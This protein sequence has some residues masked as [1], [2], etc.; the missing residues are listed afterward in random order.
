MLNFPLIYIYPV[1]TEIGLARTSFCSK[2]GRSVTFGTL[3]CPSTFHGHRSVEE[4][5]NQDWIGP[6]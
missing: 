3:S 6:R 2:L 1:I 4:R 5:V